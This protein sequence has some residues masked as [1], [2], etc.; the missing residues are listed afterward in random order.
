MF[1]VVLW[2]SGGLA[3]LPQ[4]FIA[5]Y[6]VVKGGH[7]EG[8]AQDVVFD[9]ERV[10]RLEAPRIPTTH[11]HGTGCIFSAA[12][13]AGLARGAPPIEAIRDAKV[14]ITGAIRAALPLGSGHGPANPM[15]RG[16]GG[17]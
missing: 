15:Y 6:V 13:A 2:T 10:E 7:L 14:F 4:A 5:G 3:K 8:A 1:S 16:S 11:T 17:E 12:I 9:G